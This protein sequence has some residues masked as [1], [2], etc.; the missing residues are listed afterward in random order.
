MNSP[1]PFVSPWKR[2]FDQ[3]QLLD[4]LAVRV[5]VTR[6]KPDHAKSEAYLLAVG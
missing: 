2:Q 6:R 4:T 5:N 1:D 3:S